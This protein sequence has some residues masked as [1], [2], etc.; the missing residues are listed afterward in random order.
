MTAAQRGSQSLRRQL[1]DRLGV[2]PSMKTVALV[3]LPAF[4]IVVLFVFKIYL[5]DPV[6]PAA[7]SPSQTAIVHIGR[8]TG[9]DFESRLL[10][11]VARAEAARET[12]SAWLGRAQVVPDLSRNAP[13]K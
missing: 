11:I 8:V 13:P 3:S 6:L 10:K 4:V 1:Q 7:S 5:R 9:A 2:Q 12:E